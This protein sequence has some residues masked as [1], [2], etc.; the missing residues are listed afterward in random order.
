[1]YPIF[2]DIHG[3][4]VGDRFVQFARDPHLFRSITVLERCDYRKLK[5]VIDAGVV[6]TQ[7]SRKDSVANYA[8]SARGRGKPVHEQ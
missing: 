2:N 4:I 3:K 6:D 1:M 8:V 5:L 7:H